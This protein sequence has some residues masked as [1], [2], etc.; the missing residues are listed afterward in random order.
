M[1]RHLITVLCLTLM[2]VLT[3]SWVRSVFA[4]DAFTLDL[5]QDNRLIAS[6]RQGGFI[7]ACEKAGIMLKMPHWLALAVLAVWPLFHMR[8]NVKLD[9]SK[10]VPA[11]K[12]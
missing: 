6:H 1:F 5:P 8:V 11:K 7:V 3:A 2:L 12:K 9:D 10:K 4:S